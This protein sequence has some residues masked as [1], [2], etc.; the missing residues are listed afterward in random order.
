MILVKEVSE[1]KYF[2]NKKRGLA[3]WQLP[4][5]ALW[6]QTHFALFKKKKEMF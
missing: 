1:D 5:L 4:G 3:T 2:S 6:P